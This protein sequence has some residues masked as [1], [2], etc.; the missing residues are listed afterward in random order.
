M[1]R[2]LL[3]KVVFIYDIELLNHWDHLLGPSAVVLCS[4]SDLSHRIDIIHPQ[5]RV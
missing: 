1:L 5:E 2:H 4:N 3:E